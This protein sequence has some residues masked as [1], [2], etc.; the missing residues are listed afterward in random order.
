M[1]DYWFDIQA[2]VISKRN[3]SYVRW[4]MLRLHRGVN[5]WL[6]RQLLLPEYLSNLPPPIF[7]RNYHQAQPTVLSVFIGSDL[8]EVSIDDCW[9]SY[10]RPTDQILPDIPTPY[11]VWNH[12]QE[13]PTFLSVGIG[14]E[15]TKVSIADCR[16]S[17]YWPIESLP[18]IPPPYFVRNYHQTK[19]TVMSVKI[20]S[21]FREVSIAE[22]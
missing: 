7:A 19:P 15:V 22:F 3:H 21:E 18:D 11:F 12:H 20:G 4:Y 14:S 2:Y 1:S 9:D 17:Y 8:R 16:D 13:K 5:F 10:Y 6:L